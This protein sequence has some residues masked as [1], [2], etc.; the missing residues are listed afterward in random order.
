M[1]LLVA[2]EGHYVRRGGTVYSGH[3]TYERFWKRYLSVF[4]SVSP[5]CRVRPVGEVP[6]GWLPAGGE[7]VEFIALPDYRGPWGCLRARREIDAAVRAG[8]EA[9]DAFLLR[10]PGTVSTLLWR[11]LRR[12]ALPFGVEVVGDPWEVFAP[13]VVRSPLRA[14]FRRG[15]TRAM[16]AQ[17]R[18]A[19]A[20]AYVTAETLQ[21]RYP[22]GGWTTHYSSVHL[23][24]EDFATEEQVAARAEGWL[25]RPADRPWRCAHVGS[26]AQHYKGHDTLLRAFAACVRRGVSAELDLIGDGPLRGQFAERARSLG[27]E[28]RVRFRGWLPAG[29][30]LRA[31]LDQ[32]DLLL[33]PSLTEGLPRVLLEAMARG[34]PCIA[35]DVGGVAE[36][37]GPGEMFPPGDADVLAERIREVLSQPSRLARMAGKNLEAARPYHTGV[38]TQRRIEFYRQLRQRSGG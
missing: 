23:D 13:G 24:E 14:L 35:S 12:L 7:N 16:R 37:L 10:A 17:C 4:D 34:L 11:R 29:G 36:L 21:R 5:L 1:K 38:L 18:E 28:G 6:E 20:A 15:Y 31:A 8:I 33:L 19:V 32:A 25:A 22:P 30:P 3:L 26:M 27:L 2:N 9:C